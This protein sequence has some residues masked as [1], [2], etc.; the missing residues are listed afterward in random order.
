MLALECGFAPETGFVAGSKIATSF[1]L[2]V[3][4]TLTCHTNRLITNFLYG[5][6]DNAICRF[7][8]ELCL[9]WVLSWWGNVAGFRASI[10]KWFPDSK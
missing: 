7:A 10:V 6:Q 9:L 4:L 5:S 2:F 3:W 1:V 8:L